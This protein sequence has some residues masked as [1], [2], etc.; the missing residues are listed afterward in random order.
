MIFGV[1]IPDSG[2]R[3]GMSHKEDCWLPCV[4]SIYL[5]VPR[6]SSM[7]CTVGAEL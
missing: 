2:G 4:Y 6:N 7:L 1:F 5:V 3:M